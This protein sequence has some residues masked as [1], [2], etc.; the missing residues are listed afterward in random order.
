MSQNQDTWGKEIIKGYVPQKEGHE[1]GGYAPEKRGYQSTEGNLDVSNP[2]QS[3]SG[4]PVSP[5]GGS[6]NPQE[7]E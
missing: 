2:P 4:V 6:Q 7:K 1:R 5:P 3:G